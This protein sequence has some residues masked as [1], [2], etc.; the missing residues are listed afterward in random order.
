MAVVLMCLEELVLCSREMLLPKELQGW[1][2]DFD[3][4]EFRVNSNN[5]AVRVL[6]SDPVLSES[7]VEV[8]DGFIRCLGRVP[9]I[10]VCPV[11]RCRVDDSEG[12]LNEVQCIVNVGLLKE[13][14]YQFP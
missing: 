1:L 14:V 2:D 8:S 12:H 11:P 6:V 10:Q 13:A 9:S 5:L 4:R 7:E 3:M